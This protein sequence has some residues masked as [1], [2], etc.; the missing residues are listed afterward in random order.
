MRSRLF[1]WVK[2]GLALA[3]VLFLCNYLVEHREQFAG[4]QQVKAPYAVALYVLVFAAG[5]PFAGALQVTLSVLGARTGFW[6]LVRLHFACVLLNYVPPKAGTL[7]RAN[8][9][10]RYA[11]LSYAHFSSFFLYITF[12]MASMAAWIGLLTLLMQYGIRGYANGIAAATFACIACGA[13]VPLFVPLPQLKGDGRLVSMLKAFLAGRKQIASHKRSVVASV[14]LLSLCFVLTSI[15]LVMIYRIIGVDITMAGGLLLGA[16]GS[17]VA[18]ISLTP[19][20][21]GLRELVLIAGASILGVSSEIGVL[22]AIIDRGIILSHTFVVGGI[23]ALWVLHSKRDC[24]Q[25]G[26]RVAK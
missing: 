24:R 10:K 8:Y 23:C 11:G 17:V 1:R 25:S 14:G 18:F 19:G 26:D 15:R 9:L 3:I 7:F 12:L 13:F 6:E 16:L 2:S 20:S 21:L 4:L 22:A 5:L